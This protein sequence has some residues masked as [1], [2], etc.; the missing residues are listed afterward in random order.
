MRIFR[1]RASNHTGPRR[2][3][4]FAESNFAR[5]IAEIEAGMREPVIMVGN[6]DAERDYTDV[7]DVVRAYLLAVCK[8]EPGEAYNICSGRAL[9]MRSVLD[10]LLAMSDVNVEVQIDPERLRPSDVPVL[11]GDATR[12]RKATGWKPQIPVEQT[13][14][15]L[16]S[17][18]RSKLGVHAKAG[19]RLVA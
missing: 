2:G 10:H 14:A 19:L 11:L 4:V 16:L 12:F 15:D 1:T 8:A 3:Q 13:L 9:S 7:R 5:Q 18:W 6:L 17:Y